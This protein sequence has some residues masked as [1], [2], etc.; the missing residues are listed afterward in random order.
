MQKMDKLISW[1]NDIEPIADIDL[2]IFHEYYSKTSGS[3]IGTE[4]LQ[5]N[6][7]FLKKQDIKL[8]ELTS[9]YKNDIIDKCFEI[10]TKFKEH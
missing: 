8:D 1:I 5:Y 4:R 9:F 7:E 3:A 6:K 2:N 10:I